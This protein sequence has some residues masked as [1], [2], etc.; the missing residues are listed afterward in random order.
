[1]SA[2]ASFESNSLV[3]LAMALTVYMC[4][5][6]VYGTCV[7]ILFSDYC[8]FFFLQPLLMRQH[9]LRATPW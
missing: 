9:P 5:G 3:I 2:A 6:Y 4:G 8:V 1:M 7:C